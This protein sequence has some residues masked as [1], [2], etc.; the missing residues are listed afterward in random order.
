[1]VAANVAAFAIA[2]WSETEAQRYPDKQTQVHVE[3]RVFPVWGEC[4]EAEYGFLLVEVMIVAGA[5]GY[6]GA[7]LLEAMADD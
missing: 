2:S 3:K 5:A 6:G 1:L 7:R 4:S